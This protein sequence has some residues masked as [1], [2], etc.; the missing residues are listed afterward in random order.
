MFVPDELLGRNPE[1][2]KSGIKMEFR[3]LLRR[4]FQHIFFAHGKPVI[5]QGKEMLAEF[6]AKEA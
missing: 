4:N 5:E 6:I 3:K 1:N 2:I